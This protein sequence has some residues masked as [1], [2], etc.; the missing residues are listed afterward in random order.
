MRIGVSRGAAL[1]DF[2]ARLGTRLGTLDE[3]AMTK[4]RYFKFVVP[5]QTAYLQSIDTVQEE[6]KT[7]EHAMKRK[8]VQRILRGAGAPVHDNV[9]VLSED[10]Q[11]FFTVN[12]SAIDSRHE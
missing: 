9:A 11:D 1:V 4:R 7:K 8:L 10:L 6:G 12:G 3:N 5:I 2:V